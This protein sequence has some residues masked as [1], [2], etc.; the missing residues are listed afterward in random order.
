V[1]ETEESNL[2]V[3]FHV[4]APSAERI[5]EISFIRWLSIHKPGQIRTC[6]KCFPLP[7]SVRISV[8]SAESSA[9]LSP[10]SQICLR[11]KV[12][13]RRN[14]GYFARFH[15]P[16]SIRRTFS[17]W[18]NVAAASQ[19]AILSVIAAGH[20]DDSNSPRDSLI[21]RYLAISIIIRHILLHPGMRINAEQ[22]Y[23]YT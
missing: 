5:L 23:N 12:V 6:T 20:L 4:G 10:N 15:N 21:T 14:G 7:R 18:T 19:D 9:F 3:G 1:R 2:K 8:L 22:R 17:A 13:Q 16:R 11:L